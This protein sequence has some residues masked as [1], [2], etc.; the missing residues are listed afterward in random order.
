MLPYASCPF[1]DAPNITIYQHYTHM[2]I[3][4][5]QGHPIATHN[6]WCALGCV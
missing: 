3:A 2:T 5:L 6:P 1:P 4:K